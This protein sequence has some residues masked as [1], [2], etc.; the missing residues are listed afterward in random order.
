M[1]QQFPVLITIILSTLAIVGVVLWRLR[2]QG[3]VAGLAAKLAETEKRLLEAE[4]TAS[5]KTAQAELLGIRAQ[6]AETKVAQVE[7]RAS[8]VA[9]NLRDAETRAARFE[10]VSE[11]WQQRYGEVAST[12][13]ALQAELDTVRQ[14]L[15]EALAKQDADESAARRF[16]G[17]GQKVLSDALEKANKN[18]GEL[19]KSL[20]EGSGEELG[21]HAEAVAKTLEP[22]QQKLESYDKAVAELQKNS[23]EAYGGLKD[24]IK[25][26]TEAERMLHDQA[27]ALTTALSAKPKMR[28]TFGEV[29]LRQIVEFA[30]MMAHCHFEEQA[31]R[32]TDEG[33]KIPDLVVSLPEGQKVL[34]DSKAVMDACVL[35]LQATDE[36]E[37][38]AQMKKHCENVRSRVVDL[39]SKNYFAQHQN[40]VEAVVMFLPAEYLYVAATTTNGWS[41][42]SQYDASAAVAFVLAP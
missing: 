35:A 41:R 17:I 23:S 10:Q 18:I 40:A 15:H 7:E 27:Q 29:A 31:T 14:R 6:T 33:R 21:R 3:D 22:L 8:V 39:S 36:A 42:Q 38:L 28:G 26:L 16:E 4:R 32:D 30:G 11:D 37:R 13:D 24:Q 5:A 1:A 19:A 9:N 25:S 2:P 12:K 20:K 34:V